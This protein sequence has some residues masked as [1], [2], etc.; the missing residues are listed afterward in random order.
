[1]QPYRWMWVMR[2]FG[3]IEGRILRASSPWVSNQQARSRL[4]HGRAP[5]RG[6][7]IQF[8]RHPPTDHHA[9][10]DSSQGRAD[11]T[12]PVTDTSP[13]PTVPD[14]PPGWTART[15]TPRGHRAALR[16]GCRAPGVGEGLRPVDPEAVASAA[17]GTASWTRR[18]VLVEDASGTLVAWASVHDR[19]AGRSVVEVTVAPAADEAGRRPV[20]SSRGRRRP[21]STSPACATCTAPSW[22]PVRMPPTSDSGHGSPRRATGIPGPGSR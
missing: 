2:E 16:S 17:T 13:L 8:T 18:Q 11:T 21:R 4:G 12:G 1:M 3:K 19:A 20:P 22:T 6:G 15:P 5:L 9:S 7:G 10:A 14:V